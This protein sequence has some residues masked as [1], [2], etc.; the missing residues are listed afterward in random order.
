[1]LQQVSLGLYTLHHAHYKCVSN[2]VSDATRHRDALHHAHYIHSMCCAAGL[3]S[4]YMTRIT[5]DVKHTEYVMRV[6]HIESACAVPWRH[7]T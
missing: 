3:F 1:M 5:E 4:V 2:H 6:M 7:I